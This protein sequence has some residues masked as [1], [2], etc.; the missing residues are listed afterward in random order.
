VAGILILA[1]Q[2]G[3]DGLAIRLAGAVVA[4]AAVLAIAVAGSG[5]S[6]TLPRMRLT[7]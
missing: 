6:L 4:A 2:S 5:K 7:G 1:P 3:P